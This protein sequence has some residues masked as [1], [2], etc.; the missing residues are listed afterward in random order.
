[1]WNTKQN[2]FKKYFMKYR[3]EIMWNIVKYLLYFFSLWNTVQHEKYSPYFTIFFI[4]HNIVHFIVQH[5][6]ADV[7]G[8]QTT[9]TQADAARP[10]A[11]TRRDGRGDSARDP[12]TPGRRAVARSDTR[13]GLRV[14]YS[15]WREG[16]QYLQVEAFQW[17][18]WLATAG[19]PN[20][21]LAAR[22]S[23][24]GIKFKFPWR[25]VAPRLIASQ[26]ESAKWKFW[27][28]DPPG[29]QTIYSSSTA[30]SGWQCGHD[31]TELD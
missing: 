23:Y 1:M 7:K 18:P 13:L 22:R 6:F 30:T 9:V 15:P 29:A 20:G 26:G 3:C 5:Q 2:I 14:G 12:G 31:D 24:S 17:E 4:F 28:R 11:P 10:R 16:D 8:A 25:S 19:D 21:S 27:L